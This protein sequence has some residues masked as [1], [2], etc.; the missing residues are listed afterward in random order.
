MNQ[1]CRKRARGTHQVFWRQT[2][3]G[4]REEGKR[5]LR[6]TEGEDNTALPYKY[7]FI[8]LGRVYVIDNNTHERGAR[9]TKTR[10]RR[11]RGE[12]VGA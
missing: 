7:R 11:Q 10:E 2:K 4:D 6:A 3:V 9:E 5:A 1:K 8:P 12:S